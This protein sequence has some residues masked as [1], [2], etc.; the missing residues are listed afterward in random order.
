MHEWEEIMTHGKLLF[1][2]HG[3]GHKDSNRSLLLTMCAEFHILLSQIL[4]ANKRGNVNHFGC[5]DSI[6]T[7]HQ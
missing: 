7:R 1:G 4:Y 5:S 6:S 3:I 2:H